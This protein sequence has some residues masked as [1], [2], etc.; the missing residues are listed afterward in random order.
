[1]NEQWYVAVFLHMYQ[2]L[3]NH[4]EMFAGSDNDI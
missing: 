3:K 1:M 2:C 4:N